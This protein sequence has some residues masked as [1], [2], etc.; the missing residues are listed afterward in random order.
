MKNINFFN[1]DERECQKPFKKAL[2]KR[3]LF[4]QCILHIRINEFA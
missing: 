2:S 1:L 3:L 4:I